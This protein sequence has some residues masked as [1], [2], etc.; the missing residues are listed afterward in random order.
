MTKD[1]KLKS[2]ISF[3]TK[4][5]RDYYRGSSFHW[6]GQWLEGSHYVC[7]DY[8]VDFVIY[9]HTLLACSKSHLADKENEP[10]DLITDK[11]GTVIGV[12]STYWDFVLSGIVG[13]TPGIKIQDNY[14]Y[15]CADINLPEDQQVWVNTGIKAKME[16]SDL[17]PNDIA[18]LQEPGK[19][20][21]TEFVNT[22]IVQE[23]GQNTDK[24]MSQKAVTDELADKASTS[25]LNTAISN[26]VY[27]A[28]NTYQTKGDYAT[29]TRVAIVEGD[30]AEHEQENNDKFKEIDNSL[31][32]L[33]TKIDTVE[34]DAS[35]KIFQLI[36]DLATETSNRESADT[37]TL[38]DAK[39]YTDQEKANY[40][41]KT[42]DTMTGT[43]NVPSINDFYT[44]D[45]VNICTGVSRTSCVQTN[46]IVENNIDKPNSCILLGFS[47]EG[48]M[49]FAD[50]HGQFDFYV[51]REGANINFNR[52]SHNKVA[53]LQLGQLVERNNTLTYPG[54]SG[55]FALTSDLPT[56][57]SEL[58]DDVVSGNYLPIEGTA[59]KATADAEGNTITSTYATKT[60]LTTGLANKVGY[61]TNENVSVRGT[62]ETTYTYDKSPM[63][64]S[65][66]IIIGGSAQAAGLVTRGICGVSS[67]TTT[68]ACTKSELYINYD[69]NNTYARV[70][71]L[72][73]GSS[74]SAITTSTA[75]SSTATNIYGNIF[76]AVRGDQMVNYV[77][78][79]LTVKSDVGHTHD[80]RYYTESEIDTKLDTKADLTRVETIEG[81]IPDAASSTNKLADQNWVNS[82]ISTNTATFKG[83]VSLVSALP[84][85]N[86]D[87][88]DYAFVVSTDDAG[89]TLYKRYKYTSGNWVYEYTLNNSSFTAD[90]WAAIQSGITAEKLAA[91]VTETG[92][93]TQLAKYLPL[94]GGTLTGLLNVPSIS[95]VGSITL[96]EAGTINTTGTHIDINA[97]YPRFP[98]IVA[99]T[100][101][102]DRHMMVFSPSD[103]AICK[104]GTDFTYNAGTKTVSVQNINTNTTTTAVTINAGTNAN[105]YFQS[106][107]FRGQGN[108]SEY[109]H[110]I[111][112]GYSGHNQV[113]FYEYG[114]K[115]NFWQNQSA[116]KPTD[117][118]NIIASLQRG[119]LVEQ[120]NTLTY[121]G[122]SGTI[123]LT[124]DIPTVPTKL[125]EFTDDVV[126]GNYLPIDGT[127]VKATADASGNVITDTYATKAELREVITDAEKVEEATAGILYGIDERLD[128]LET[129]IT[130]ISAISDDEINTI[131]V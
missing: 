124:S 77:T 126:S 94:T 85:T 60:E 31:D 56:K 100:S 92:L 25:A 114:G 87:E 45:T 82:S 21:V 1:I 118:S 130:A 34:G 42:G 99:A 75:K 78:D 61:T 129:S 3:A 38:T 51:K 88:N 73:A 66:G 91:L 17:T 71:V 57:L 33:N 24:L 22:T 90:Q 67:P 9:N 122:K 8:T 35:T 48:L 102:S 20:L 68:G 54:K 117:E 6:S 2:N 41:L 15:T 52:S 84:T 95:S 115:Y 49:E 26:E 39:A 106:Q 55:T 70:L 65:G 47:D 37:Q 46:A 125:S 111:D 12:V 5:S 80:D 109:R 32:T 107:K 29:N 19:Q 121:P 63:V 116:T 7:D 10:K 98:N 113:D 18:L 13:G 108:A 43:L 11:T 53:S 28:N 62:T 4:A 96:D 93:S 83:T 97:M 72:G 101:N 119:K 86:V 120:G 89:N 127:A 23:T 131:C 59:V 105:S 76:S 50:Y 103:S 16:L 14:W 112:F 104:T 40:V 30:L 64:V 74:G 36:T 69:G 128:V 110:A 44:K 58:T 79:K 81:K 27:R 123:A